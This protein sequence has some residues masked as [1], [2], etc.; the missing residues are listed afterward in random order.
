MTEL[1]NQLK[2][3]LEW[4]ERETGLV[5]SGNREQ[6]AVMGIERVMESVN[7]RGPFDFL[8]RLK[9]DKL[10]RRMVI[11]QLTVGETYFFRDAGQFEFIKREIIPAWRREPEQRTVWSAGCS[12]G[13]EAYSLAILFH[14]QGLGHR[15]DVI[16][17]DISEEALDMAR[18][19][20][21]RNWSLRGLRADSLGRFVRTVGN[22][23]VLSDDIKQRVRF[24]QLNLADGKYPSAGAGVTDL[25][26]IVCRN[27]LIYLNS[28]VIKNVIVRMYDSLR[29]GGWLILGATDPQV[30]DLAPWTIKSNV[31][32]VFYQRP[33]EASGHAGSGRMVTRLVSEEPVLSARSLADASGYHA[34]PRGTR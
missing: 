33:Y 16:G 17:S 20:V 2:P 8:K 29:P 27:V 3:V 25:D 26:L 1:S 34:T 6:A 30:A 5:L 28:E 11:S 15:V 31:N 4:L 7:I 12:S 10:V 18:R 22:E 23:H 19:A 32:G 24:F 14:E 21:Y 9:S 13:E